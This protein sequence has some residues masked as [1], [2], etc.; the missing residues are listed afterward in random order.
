ML[1]QEF[2]QWRLVPKN[3]ERVKQ[4]TLDDQ[5]DIFYKEYFNQVGLNQIILE[6]ASQVHDLQI[7]IE[8]LIED[9]C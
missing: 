4:E 3:I 8:G 1:M 2:K 7:C 9:N 6:L 5:F